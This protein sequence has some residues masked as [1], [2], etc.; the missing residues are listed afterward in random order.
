MFETGQKVWL[1]Y[2][3][4]QQPEEC[5][6]VGAVP[7]EFFPTRVFITYPGDHEADEDEETSDELYGTL[8]EAKAARAVYL[9]ER[10]RLGQRKVGEAQTDLNCASAELEHSLL[11][12]RKLQGSIT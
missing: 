7:T 1:Y 11:E 9:A 10:V 5:V 2:G 3:G 8:L 12:I 6:F 4:Y